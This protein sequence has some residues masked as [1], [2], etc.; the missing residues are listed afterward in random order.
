MLEGPY[1]T[2]LIAK[3]H[4]LLPGSIVLKNDANYMQGMLDLVVFYGPRYGMLEVKTKRPTSEDDFEP[5]QEYYIAL[6]ADW[7][8]GACIFPENE[9]EVL[10]E[11]QQA[12]RT[13]RTPRV[14]KP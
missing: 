14:L 13:R 8:F 12:L 10:R 6:F 2:K 5:N 11:L 1:K 7:A 4:K 3:I 9:E